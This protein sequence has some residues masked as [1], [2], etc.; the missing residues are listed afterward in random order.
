MALLG[1]GLC[2]AVAPARGQ[3]RSGT[4]R[5][6]FLSQQ[7]QGQTS[8]FAEAFVDGLRDAGYVE[9]QNLTIEWRFAQDREGLVA[10]ANELAQMKLGAIVTT[11]GPAVRALRQATSTTPI[12]MSFS[13]DP[14]G[15]GLV[16]SLSRPGGNLTGPS[17]M[18][19][20]LSAK[21]VE[22]L[23]EAFPAA[24]RVAT[25]WNPEDPVYALEL[26][27]TERA[28][29]SLGRTLL[30]IA[31]RS[32]T[33]F[34]TAFAEMVGARADA[35]IVFAHTLTILNRRSLIDLANR[36]R[37]PTMYGLIEYVTDGGLIAYGPRLAEV[38]RRA[39]VYVDRILKGGNPADLPIE[40][41]SKF[42]LA[43]NLKTV[44]ALGLDMPSALL[45]RADEVIE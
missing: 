14:V 5:I 7:P 17:F 31:V 44:K 41:P 23:A 25:L 43:I 13:G 33:E 4:H 20:D 30:P 36:H 29:R 22:V 16:P 2:I 27:R 18:S 42:E 38:Y 3:P 26:E 40:Q 32:P 45:A 39:A 28:V 8:S 37:M 12:I 1:G 11:G 9:G 35:L 6:G 19:P 24:Q 10:F 34:E 15:T 21:R